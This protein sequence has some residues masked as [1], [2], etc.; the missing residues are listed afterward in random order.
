MRS[1]PDS[2]AWSAF[3]THNPSP[4][5]RHKGGWQR[6]SRLTWPC[7]PFLQF[8]G[9]TPFRPLLR[10]LVAQ[11]ARDFGRLGLHKGFLRRLGEMLGAIPD[12]QAAVMAPAGLR[13]EEASRT[14][15]SLADEKDPGLAALRLR[16]HAEALADVFFAIC[17]A[18]DIATEGDSGRREKETAL[19]EH[20]VATWLGANQE[21][22][23]RGYADR[24]R[25]VAEF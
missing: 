24:V 10:L 17:L 7:D 3:P 18:Q 21:E 13:L 4:R 9:S 12:E 16:P 19:L 8:P 11:T 15:T 5:C 25:K 23:D 14:I 6:E 2:A 20:F 22:H 1:A